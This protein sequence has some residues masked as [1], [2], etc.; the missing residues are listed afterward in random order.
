MHSYLN[1]F[2]TIFVVQVLYILTVTVTMVMERSKNIFRLLSGWGYF[3]LNY[4]VL[5]SELLCL[6]SGEFVAVFS[7][8]TAMITT[9]QRFSSERS[10][11]IEY[12]EE[13]HLEK[14]QLIKK[15]KPGGI[16]AIPLGSGTQNRN[17]GWVGNFYLLSDHHIRR[18]FHRF[19]LFFLSK[20]L[21]S[22][23]NGKTKLFMSGNSTLKRLS[24]F[25]IYL[26]TSV[27]FKK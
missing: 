26:K 8:C 25:F 9:E 12:C 22:S 24:K 4:T 6:D 7:H 15:G 10:F 3:M 16:A 20:F 19:F 14:S 18:S 5:W 11:C 17:F 13:W 21:M 23:P 27:N 1:R 2:K